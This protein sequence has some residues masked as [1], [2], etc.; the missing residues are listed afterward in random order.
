[1]SGHG[2]REAMLR[3][4]AARWRDQ[5]AI[6]ITSTAAIAAMSERGVSIDALA[7]AVGRIASHIAAGEDTIE[8]HSVQARRAA[9]FLEARGHIVRVDADLIRPVRD[10][11]LI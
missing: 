9:K 8:M 1:M 6:D 3:A 11:E 2:G 7:A 4:D 5:V 10:G